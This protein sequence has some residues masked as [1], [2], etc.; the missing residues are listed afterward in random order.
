MVFSLCALFSPMTLTY[1][2]WCVV[3][4]HPGGFRT[5]CSAIQR[6]LLDTE[7]LCMRVCVKIAGA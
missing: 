3:H 1:E 5:L 7:T 2:S 4:R 6:I